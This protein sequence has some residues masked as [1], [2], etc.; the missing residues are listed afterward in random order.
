MNARI[1][2]V[3]SLLFV[4]SFTEASNESDGSHLKSYAN[5]DETDSHAARAEASSAVN[6]DSEGET[7]DKMVKDVP[8][9]AGA[10]VED[11]EESDGGQRSTRGLNPEEYE[12]KGDPNVHGRFDETN[13]DAD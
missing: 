3:M 10:S 11:A 5:R 1:L 12:P 6:S 4:T 7:E 9:E 13:E 2:I 8:E